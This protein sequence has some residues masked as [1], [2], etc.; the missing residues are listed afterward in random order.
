LFR[1][2]PDAFLGENVN[3]LKA[4]A[5]LNVPEK[6][7][8]ESVSPAE[9]RKIYVAQTSDWNTYRQKLAAT[10]KTAAKADEAGAQA[11]SGKITAKVEEKLVPAEQSKDQVKVA[12]TDA[13][14]K[15]TTDAK[16]AE[17]A[18]QV[19]KEKALKDAQERLAVL[20]K[21][22]NELQKL[23]EM[24]NQKLA[25]LQQPAKKDE[26]K[27]VEAVNRLKLRSR[28]QGRGGCQAS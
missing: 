6:S 8:V 23:L 19:A 12:R 25:E 14:A 21:N 26:P 10:S 18:E 20:E 16:A 4:G 11:S 1:N 3:R 13:A 2:N 5:I 28:T 15:G 7:V 9:A 27:P 24:K 22:V 17:T